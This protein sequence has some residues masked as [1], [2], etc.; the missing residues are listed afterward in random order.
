MSAAISHMADKILPLIGED[1]TLSE[2][3]EIIARCREGDASAFRELYRLHRSSVFRVVAG[4]IVN[5][6]DREEVTQDV[7]LQ[8]FRSIHNFKGNS[9]LSTWIHRV[10]MNVILQYIR[11][12][13]SRV[14]LHLEERIP[15]HINAVPVGGSAPVNPE[16]RAFQS[17]RR[18]AVERAL[19][20][21]SEKKRG[22]FVLHD[23]EGLKAAEIAKIVGVSV[24]TVRTR[25]FYARKDFYQH[26][27]GEPACADL[28]LTQEVG[29]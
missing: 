13:K 14:R 23:F 22:A 8:V 7:F 2:D 25:I 9:K 29:E 27:A 15:D 6:A 10:T 3:D 20:A 1:K 26:L 16:E 24:L 12:K 4:M 17:E 5:Q 19:A 18:Q 11:R 28:Q 21:L